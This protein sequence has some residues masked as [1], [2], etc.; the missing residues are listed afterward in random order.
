MSYTLI[1]TIAGVAALN[2][3]ALWILFFG[4]ADWLEGTGLFVWQTRRQWRADAPTM[5]AGVFKAFACVAITIE[6]G[7]VVLAMLAL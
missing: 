5:S 7:V 1:A 4:G 2:L 3:A 6:F